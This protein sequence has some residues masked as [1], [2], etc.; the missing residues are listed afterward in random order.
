VINIIS[1]VIIIAPVMIT[2]V[3]LMSVPAAFAEVPVN[4]GDGHADFL[5]G[6]PNNNS[7][8]PANGDAYC[9]SYEIG[10]GIGWAAAHQLYCGAN[11]QSTNC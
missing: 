11:P 6:N 10:Y 4:T 5:N 9:A 8:N 7:C 1:N 3:L 2:T